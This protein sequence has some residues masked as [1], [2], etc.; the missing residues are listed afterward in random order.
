MKFYNTVVL[1]LLCFSA[2]GQSPLSKRTVH[3]YLIHEKAEELVGIKTGPFVRLDNG[4]ILTVEKNMS[5]ISMDEGKTW[6][7]YSIFQDSA[8]FDIRIERVLLK[9][10]S[11]AIILAFANN[12]E[13]ANWNWDTS[14]SDS[15]GARIPTYT[16]R[17]LDGGKSW[18]DLQMLHEEWT[19]ANRDIIETKEGNIIF[20]SMMMRHNP[21]HHTTITY[22]SKT[23]GF[24]WKRSN[25][26][27]RG[28]VGHHSGVIEST[29]EQLED[30]R[31]WMLMRTNWGVFWE[32]YSDNQ[33]LLWKNIR[34]TKID[35]ASAPGLL[36]R[37]SSGRLVL[38]WNR[39][40]PEGESSYSLSGGDGQHSEVAHSN[41]RKELS[42]MFSD[43][44]GTTWSN[45]VV[46]AKVTDESK[47]KNLAYPR[48]FEAR[49]GELWVTTTYANFGGFLGVK[50]LEKDFLK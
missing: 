1:I 3:G 42:I 18:Q 33:G 5:C 46:F 25:V 17:S 22:T 34:P 4:G 15:P 20:T 31:I 41:H 26:I 45:P 23:N 43:D 12:K 39:K 19:G 7:Y 36:K 47:T 9:T 49:P 29:I 35:M 2:F 32:A 38:V 24:N 44:D 14:I 40:Y 10:S 11:G 37:L 13:R 27:D 48:V 30:G 28:G 50:L 16:V 21:G 6:E 8:K